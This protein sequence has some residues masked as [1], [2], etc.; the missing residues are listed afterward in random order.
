V[1]ELAQRARAIWRHSERQLANDRDWEKD[2]PGR[3]DGASC[4]SPDG[5]ESAMIHR[6]VLALPDANTSA[7]GGPAF[8]IKD[9]T[10]VDVREIRQASGIE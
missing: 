3:D 10:E 5:E 7:Q 6:V 9:V 2:P 8:S 1:P 4:W